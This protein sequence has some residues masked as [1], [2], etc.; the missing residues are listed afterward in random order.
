[1]LT[2]PP[3]PTGPPPGGSLSPART[4]RRTLLLCAWLAVSCGGAG[5]PAGPARADEA[6]DGGE[7][8]GRRDAPS[9]RL[10]LDPAP[11]YPFLS[12]ASDPL[13]PFF[14]R[15]DVRG[16]W[17]PA[18]WHALLVDLGVSAARD[19]RPHLGLAW[20]LWPMGEGLRGC[21]VAA[22]VDL[23]SPRQQDQGRRLGSLDLRAEA[24]GQAVWDGWLLGASAGLR[25]R[26][27]GGAGEPRGLGWRLALW[28]GFALAV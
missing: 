11:A 24:G 12:F 25:R 18:R 22:G 26:L 8:T 1:M 13:G 27:V 3:P 2:S 23:L 7:V 21:W 9:Q 20:S 6:A 19:H 28:V 17:A 16:G 4:P 15:Y 10:D 14:G 5:L